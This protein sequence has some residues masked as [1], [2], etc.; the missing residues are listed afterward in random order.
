M[1]TA[2]ELAAQWL[3]MH[4]GLRLKPYRCTANKR[5]IGYGRN[6]DDVGIT[7]AE[8]DYLLVA[9]VARAVRAAEH[10]VAN[11]YTLNPVRQAVLI[12]M[13]FNLGARGLA[14]FVNMRTAIEGENFAEAA[15]HM[16]NSTWAKQVKGRAVFLAEKMRGEHGTSL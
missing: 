14:G 16:L 9:D 13:A 3:R 10:L 15:Q 1:Q 5:T 7:E 11:F 12:D 2:C 4:E 6:L 8:A